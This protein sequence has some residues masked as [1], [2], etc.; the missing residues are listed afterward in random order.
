VQDV[1]RFLEPRDIH[2]PENAAGIADAD[3]PS[4]CTDLIEGLPVSRIKSG[5]DF[6]S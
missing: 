5:L 2:H 1:N 4:A 3:F 6:P